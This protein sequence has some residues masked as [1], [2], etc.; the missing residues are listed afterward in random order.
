MSGLHVYEKRH[1]KVLAQRSGKLQSQLPSIAGVGLL[2]VG[3]GWKGPM[4]CQKCKRGELNRVSRAGLMQRLI[5][6]LLGL[7]PWECGVC[8]DRSLCRTR[9]DYSRK[10]HDTRIF[11][12][13]E[14]PVRIDGQP[15]VRE[16]DP[17]TFSERLLD[18]DRSRSSQT[19]SGHAQ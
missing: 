1:L 2:L 18:G 7:F 4:Q 3:V 15:F 5:L 13:D 19:G 11:P 10:D 14:Y 16:T 12:N 17:R 9:G 8:K 6:P